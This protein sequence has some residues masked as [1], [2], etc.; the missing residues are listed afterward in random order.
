MSLVLALWSARAK[1]QAG[2]Q[3]LG[4]RHEGQGGCLAASVEK[5]IDDRAVQR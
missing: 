4:V 1:P 2:A 5:Q 3:H